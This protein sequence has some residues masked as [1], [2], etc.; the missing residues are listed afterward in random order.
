MLGL[1]CHGRYTVRYLSAK[2]RNNE[3][4][5]KIFKTKEKPQIDE[6]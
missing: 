3:F 6:I 5:E 4:M 2:K 1:E